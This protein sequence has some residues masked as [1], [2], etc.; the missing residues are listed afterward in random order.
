MRFFV[1]LH[2]PWQARHFASAFVSVNRL[3]GRRKPLGTSWI[4]D[5]GAFTEISTHGR[6]RFS[7]A[8]Y[9]AEINRLAER[10]PGLLAA[11]AQ[12]FM[13]EPVIL[14][15]TG[16]TIERHQAL[17]LE[18]FDE[19]REL[20][21]APVIP[22]LQGYDAADYVRHLTMYGDRFAP[23]AWVGVGS[24]CKRNAS[25]TSIEIILAE[26]RRRR[27]DLR[28]HGF[29][30]KTTA[31]GLAAVR[32]HLFSADSMAWSYAARRQGRNQNCWHEAARFVER[33]ERMP[34]QTSLLTEVTQWQTSST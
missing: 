2:K 9:A 22:V 23:G 10:D 15:R 24:L 20:V 7:V 11:V 1:G 34:V 27:P 16:L 18:R 21:R 33:I 3:R 25:P 29:G 6:Y 17:T 8:D 32:D 30:L 12:D 26:I 14:A 28:L 13:C 19:L 31:L 5:S 4:M